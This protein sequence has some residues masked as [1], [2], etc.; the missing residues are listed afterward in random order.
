MKVVLSV[1]LLGLQK[2]TNPV[3]APFNRDGTIL[4]LKN[5]NSGGTNAATSATFTTSYLPHSMNTFGRNYLCRS[6]HS[7]D[8]CLAHVPN[9]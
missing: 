9:C 1:L 8:T 3:G 2:A 7:A 6:M 5:I 4:F